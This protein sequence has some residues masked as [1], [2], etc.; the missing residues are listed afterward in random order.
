MPTGAVAQAVMASVRRGQQQDPHGTGSGV[1]VAHSVHAQSPGC[2]VTDS[3]GTPIST[4]QLTQE[5][6]GFCAF[7]TLQNSTP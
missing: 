1:T 2:P 4:Q 7:R 6:V 5:K 3:K